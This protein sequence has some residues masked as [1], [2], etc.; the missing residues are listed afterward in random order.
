MFI[1]GIAF[2]CGLFLLI[3]SA[4]LFLQKT[5]LKK[6]GRILAVIYLLLSLWLFNVVL[7]YTGLHKS[8][9]ML[10]TCYYPIDLIISLCVN[11]LMYHYV[12]KLSS[13]HRPLKAEHL[14][15]Q[16]IPALI[17][18]GFVIHFSTISESERINLLITEKIAHSPMWNI[19]ISTFYIQSFTYIYF[20]SKR[21]H[22]IGK[23][24]VI[25]Y[26]NNHILKPQWIKHLMWYNAL[27][28][29]I[30]M[31]VR[32]IF[33]SLLIHLE[34]VMC[35]ICVLAVYLA[36]VSFNHTGLAAGNYDLNEHDF[37]NLDETDEDEDGDE[38]E[39][40]GEGEGEDEENE[41]AVPEPEEVKAISV[42]VHELLV[43]ESLF[44]SMKCPI[45]TVAERIGY[46]PQT[47]SLALKQ[48][49]DLNY[50]DFINSYRV[51]H[52]CSLMESGALSELTME[53]VAKASGF[54]S[55]GNFF[56]A[57]KKATGTTPLRYIKEMYPANIMLNDDDD[58]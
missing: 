12:R 34:T 22:A 25:V 16:F 39:D 54:G 18:I 14:Q 49:T 4:I 13:P 23:S 3:L 35:L 44:L 30:Y 7:L 40:E 53:G 11:P 55:K 38:D 56:G 51:K 52:A 41:E 32:I 47:V 2:S 37:F 33:K 57:F 58:Y 45:L 36:S 42:A 20:C 50:T 24:Q 19:I 10:L 43:S 29:I 31:I 1:T 17:V 46:S 26:K 48:E 8:D 28:L 9:R 27:A 15:L 5:A 6:P 21:M